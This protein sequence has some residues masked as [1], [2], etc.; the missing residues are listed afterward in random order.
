MHKDHRDT[1]PRDRPIDVIT[2][3]KP[4]ADTARYLARGNDFVSR[5]WTDGKWKPGDLIG[6]NGSSS[7]AKQQSATYASRDKAEKLT[8]PR[9][10]TSTGHIMHH[11]RPP[12]VCLGWGGYDKFT[13]WQANGRQIA[14]EMVEKEDWSTDLTEN[15]DFVDESGDV[16]DTVPAA[17]EP[18]DLPNR[19]Q[20]PVTLYDLL[21]PGD[22][23]RPRIA[24][25]RILALP[26]TVNRQR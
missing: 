1:R 5:V 20:K 14:K 26:G 22:A 2:T 25:E 10:A 18:Q 6:S 11:D 19:T 17:I 8:E 24:P 21:N 7:E 4:A 3:D 12:I 16:V 23:K 13:Q 9:S 15:V